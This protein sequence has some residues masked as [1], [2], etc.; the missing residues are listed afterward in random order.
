MRTLKQELFPVAPHIEY[1]LK[2]ERETRCEYGGRIRFD[3]TATGIVVSC[4]GY[5]HMDLHTVEAALRKLGC[6][7]DHSKGLQQFDS[8]SGRTY[9]YFIEPK[10]V[11]GAQ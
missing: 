11:G 4:E 2:A 6:K 8:M 7:Y 5:Q 9:T 10:A 1:L 3:R